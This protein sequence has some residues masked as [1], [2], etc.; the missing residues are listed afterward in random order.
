ME[1]LHEERDIRIVV[2]IP[3]D[4]RF[5]G[6]CQD[7]EEML[8]NLMDN[9]CKWAKTRVELRSRRDG[10][11]LIVTVDDDGP[12]LSQEERESAFARGRRLD[13]AVPGTGLGLGITRELAELYGGEVRLE[14]SRMGGLR[15]VLRLPAERK[16]SKQVMARRAG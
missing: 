6:E 2:E 16:L 8:G 7:L 5:R 9:A 13:E 12:G 15:A 3:P 4:H 10:D 1:R 11:Y 14:N